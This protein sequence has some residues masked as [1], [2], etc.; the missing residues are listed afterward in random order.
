MAIQLGCR[1][2]TVCLSWPIGPQI[3]CIIVVAAGKVFVK[4]FKLSSA[5]SALCS[6]LGMPN[7]SAHRCNM[8]ATMLW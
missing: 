2:L 3:V 8:M 1:I 5:Y 4:C 6:R 7:C